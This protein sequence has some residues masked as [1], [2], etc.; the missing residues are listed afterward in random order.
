M[1]RCLRVGAVLVLAWSMFG[2]GAST[3]QEVLVPAI[4]AVPSDA[5]VVLEIPHPELLLDPALGPKVQKL[6]ESRP[7]YRE[8]VQKPGFQQFRQIVQFIE[9]QVG[10]DW[11]TGVRSLLAG[12]ITLA[13]HP[14]GGAVLIVDGRDESLLRKLHE[15]LVN[16][17]RDSASR[18]GRP[19]PVVRRDL[20]GVE[21]WSFDGKEAHALLGRR[22]VFA[23]R[24]DV[25]EATLKVLN[26][27]TTATGISGTKAYGQAREAAGTKAAA[28]LFADLA[29]LRRS[30]KLQAALTPSTNPLGALLTGPVLD[31][32]GRSNW[33]SLAMDLEG[34]RIALT[35]AMDAPPVAADGPTAFA[36]PGAGAG[37]LPNFQVPR[38]IV[39]LSAYRDLRAFYTAK[40]RLFP[41]RTSGLI[42]FEN[43]MGI[44]FSGR[45]LTEEVF[46]ALRPELRFVV[47]G[48]AYDP[49]VGTPQV[50][51]PAFALVARVNDPDAF[52]AVAE[53]AWQKAVG[54]INVT[55]GQKAE[56]GLI[57]DRVTHGDVR[58]SVAINSPAKG[59]DPARLPLRYNFRP[60]LARV[61]DVMILGSTEGLTRDLIDALKPAATPAP[62][63]GV[64]TLVALDGSSLAT[65]LQADRDYLVQ[66]NMVEKGS[67]QA[68][69]ERSIDAVIA[70]ARLL[71]RGEL[72]GWT[73]DGQA[74]LRLE[75]SPRIP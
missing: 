63:A 61:G 45:D 36:A 48:Q 35:A 69:A 8:Q 2:R 9:A 56:P 58:F 37:A 49:A 72:R 11:K 74:R 26:A 21:T 30:P 71:N 70:I 10:T 3:G 27:P 4:Q 13:V 32:L 73:Q 44:F 65:I 50:Q 28:T 68:E 7:E 18:E 23:T 42:F 52:Q 62:V 43:M 14:D 16:G 46:A 64:H 39:G 25:L 53:E 67:T 33:L 75:F 66:Q 5:V 31:E 24:P 55:R 60:T 1:S 19:D 38:Q 17:T 40:D 57:I 59:E 34:D 41:E 54:L 47:A 12:G 22:L 20:A 51:V 15:V 6:L 29:A